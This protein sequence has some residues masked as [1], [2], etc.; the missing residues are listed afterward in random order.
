MDEYLI[1]FILDEYAPQVDLFKVFRLVSK[2]Y[3]E[4]SCFLVHLQ[5]QRPFEDF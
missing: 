4:I 3:R 1:T 5:P 2:R